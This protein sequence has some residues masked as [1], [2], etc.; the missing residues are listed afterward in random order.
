MGGVWIHIV[1]I[2][3]S[4]LGVEGLN[5]HATSLH[6]NICYVFKADLSMFSIKKFRGVAHGNAKIA[7]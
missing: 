6:Q 7:S 1:T 5:T 2:V 4:I 3:L